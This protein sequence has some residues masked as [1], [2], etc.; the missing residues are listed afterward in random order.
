M[1]PLLQS[2]PPTREVAQAQHSSVM[3]TSETWDQ[4]S[5]GRLQCRWSCVLPRVQ[6]LAIRGPIGLYSRWGGTGTAT[7]TA[8]PASC[9]AGKCWGRISPHALQGRSAQAQGLPSAGV[10]PRAEG[11]THPDPSLLRRT[12]VAGCLPL[13]SS[14]P[15]TEP[16]E[17]GQPAAG[18]RLCPL[19]PTSSCPTRLRWLPNPQCTAG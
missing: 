19:T 5:E 1:Q 3:P 8:C 12:E 9:P 2:S 4:Y 13:P 14:W 7:H 18:A 15:L 17:T 11:D 6:G 16:T 10:Q